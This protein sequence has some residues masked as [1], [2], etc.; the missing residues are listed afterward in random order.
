MEDKKYELVE[1]DFIIYKGRK[2][3]R[4][5]ALKNSICYRYGITYKGDLGGYIEGYHNLSQEGKCWV[6]SNAKV[7][8]NARI[9]DD[10]AV[11]AGEDIE[12]FGNA[13][14][15]NSAVVS[16]SVKIYENAVVRNSAKVSDNARVYGNAV[17]KDSSVVYGNTCVNGNAIV[18]GPI[19]VKGDTKISDNAV[20][21]EK[22]NGNIDSALCCRVEGADICDN[23]EIRGRQ[24]RMT[25]RDKLL[26]NSIIS[27]HGK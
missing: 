19:I 21:S 3:Y 27:H 10:A 7:Y 26:N 9:E 13:I 6:F 16:D 14:I 22:I 5:R 18:K 2:L 11:V 1:D 24:T 23:A 4:I 20:V 17:I 12:V 25:F 8:D 15:K